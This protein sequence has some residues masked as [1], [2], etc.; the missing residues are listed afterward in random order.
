MIDMAITKV[1]I[2]DLNA[3]SEEEL[4]LKNTVRDFADRELAPRAADYD[5]SGEFPWDNFKAIADL[6]LF[7]LGIE[8]E[9]GGS[10]GTTRQ[11][12]VVAEE[13]NHHPDIYFTWGRAK[14]EIRT[15]AI[16]GLTE[17]DFILAAKIDRLPR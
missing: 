14:L 15:H 7:G 10:G 13:Q 6:G 17:N 2:L 16:D 1:K 8:E 11:V 3:L 5:E 12:A 4:L 9:Y